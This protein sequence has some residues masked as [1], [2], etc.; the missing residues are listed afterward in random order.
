MGRK[1]EYI[2]EII[3]LIKGQKLVMRTAQG[4]FPMETIYTW[5]VID[6]NTTKMTLRNKGNPA[7]FSKLLT[8]FMAFMM[9]KA[10]NKD[11]V[12]IKRIIENR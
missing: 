9:R 5:N 6:E 7:G 11:L 4:P 3:E 10:N 8:P 1:L 2:Y 12:N